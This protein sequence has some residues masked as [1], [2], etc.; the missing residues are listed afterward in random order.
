MREYLHRLL[1][2]QYNPVYEKD[3]DAF[4]TCAATPPQ[5]GWA[6]IPLDRCGIDQPVPERLPLHLIRAR[7]SYR[8]TS[9]RDLHPATDKSAGST[10]DRYPGNP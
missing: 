1:I 2:P 10:L 4:H 3:P 6:T 8:T 9:I 5:V 7:D